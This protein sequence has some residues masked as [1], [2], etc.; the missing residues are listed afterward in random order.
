VSPTL[1]AA[2]RRLRL[3]L[4]TLGGAKRGFFIPYRHAATVEPQG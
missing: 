4:A 2:A 3:G 1:R